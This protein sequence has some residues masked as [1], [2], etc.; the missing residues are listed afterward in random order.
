MKR[1]QRPFLLVLLSES[2]NQ[3]K[4]VLLESVE[5]L[6]ERMICVKWG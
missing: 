1:F 4:D 5:L 6:Q 3:L 2:L